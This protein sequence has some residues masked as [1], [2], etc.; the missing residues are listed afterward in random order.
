MRMT[1]SNSDSIIIIRSKIM[2]DKPIQIEKLE[3]TECIIRYL[4]NIN[5]ND[6]SKDIKE[7]KNSELDRLKKEHSELEL[8]NASDTD[9][10]IMALFEMEDIYHVYY[11]DN[12]VNKIK[13][14]RNRFLESQDE[15]PVPK[16]PKKK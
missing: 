5:D 14:V 12:I 8:L 9:I 13:E 15:I 16:L 11:R 4:N 1:E 3:Q 10:I 7:W 6:L 2:D